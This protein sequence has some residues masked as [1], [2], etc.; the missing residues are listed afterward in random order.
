MALSRSLAISRLAL[1][2][3]DRAFAC[4]LGWLWEETP[5]IWDISDAA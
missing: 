3:N 1:H 5:G 2:Q 4:Q